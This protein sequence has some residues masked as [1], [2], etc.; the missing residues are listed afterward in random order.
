MEADMGYEISRYAFVTYTHA[1]LENTFPL[2]LPLLD[3]E[4]DLEH[5]LTARQQH[6]TTSPSGTNRVL[7]PGRHAAC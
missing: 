6:L 4:L 1:I 5:Y 7:P 2:P 3:P